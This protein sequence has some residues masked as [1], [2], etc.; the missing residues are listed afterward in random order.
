M[1][2][3]AAALASLYDERERLERRISEREVRLEVDGH[4]NFDWASAGELLSG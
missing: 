2:V 1:D 4:E 3:V